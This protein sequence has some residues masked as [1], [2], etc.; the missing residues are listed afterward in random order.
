MLA[1]KTKI[2]LLAF[3]VISIVA[4]AY[5]LVRFTDI[6]ESF[7]G[8]GYTVQLELRESG[9]IFADAEV[10]YRGYNVGKVEELN[11]TEEGLRA[12][13]AIDG[14]APDISSDLQAVVANR[15]AVGE[16]YVD[17]RPVNDEGSVLQEGSRIP[18]DRTLTPVGAEEIIADIDALAGA[19]P[20][21]DLQ[22]V[23]DESYN[24]FQGTGE[25]LQV[26]MD[27]TRDFTR[28]AED[29][30]PQTV[31]LLEQGNTVLSTQ[32]ELSGSMRS[33]SRDLRDLS[34]T[35]QDSDGDI[36]ELIEAGPG[37]AH[38][39]GSLVEETGPG[40]SGLLANLLTTSHILEPRLDGVEQALVSYPAISGAAKTVVPGDG[41]AH[42]GLALN[43]FD[44]PSCTQGYRSPEEYRPGDETTTRSPKNDAYCAEPP[45]SPISV[46]GSQNAPYRGVP[47]TPSDEQLQANSDR[48]QEEL[49]SL[50]GVPGVSGSPGL[51]IASLS[52]LMGLPE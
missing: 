38:Q 52:E 45:G 43:L 41:T 4:I 50:R 44:P 51:D 12:D 6:E 14:D 25:D 1:R 5:A 34:A 8:G 15:S 18:A 20:E 11:L 2:Q 23:V 46:R 39:V 31:Q 40:L 47:S 42:L 3:L 17:L 9:G 16:Q 29:H 10:T 21:D 26:L 36:R 24:A 30:L 48:D 7:G 49:A 28:T 33:F 35:L 22:T 13:L 19:V 27:T 32:N 37:A